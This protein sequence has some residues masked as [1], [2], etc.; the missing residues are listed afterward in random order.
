MSGLLARAIGDLTA[1]FVAAGGGRNGLPSAPMWFGFLRTIPMDAGVSATVTVTVKELPALSRLSK[2]AVRQLVGAATRASWIEG[3]GSK[4][5]VGLTG[6][7]RDAAVAWAALIGPTE[8]RW[9]ARVGAE[10]GEL[11]STLAAVVAELDLELPHYPI[12]YG[13]VDPSITGAFPFRPADPGPPR[14][15]ARS[16]DWAPVIRNKDDRDTVAALPLTALLSQLLAAFIV[17]YAGAGGGLLS[18]AEGLFRAFGAADTAPM[19]DLPSFL[20]V[21]GRGKSGLERHGILSVRDRTAHLTPLGHRIRDGYTALPRWVESDWAARFGSPCVTA[22]RDALEAML[23][24]LD[25]ALP[26]MLLATHV[27]S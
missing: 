12:S 26:D 3:Q 4:S 7:G 16:Q 19:Q 17:D 27:T 23:P 13:S 22:V 14:I 21:D 1:E 8:A 18:I 11:R 15:P 2:R 6:A 20:G 25:P 10:E 24:A 5:T 9:A